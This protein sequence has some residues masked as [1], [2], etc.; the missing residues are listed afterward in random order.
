MRAFALG[1][2]GGDGE[3]AFV[4]KELEVEAGKQDVGVC[5]MGGLFMV[6]LI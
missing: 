4:F 1:T 3:E 6:C 5:K 2:V